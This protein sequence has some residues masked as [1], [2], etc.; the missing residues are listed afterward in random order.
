MIDD[1]S[2]SRKTFAAESPWPRSG[3][4]A[5]ICGRNEVRDPCSAS[6]DWAHARSA[7]AASRRARTSPSA[8]NDAMNCVPLISESPSFA[9]SRNGSSPTRASASSPGSRSPSTNA[10]PSPTSGSARC[11]SGARSPDAPTEP[12]LGT[13]GT[14]PR[15]RHSS[16][17]ST[18]S[19]RAP[20][21]PFGQ[22]VR[23][24]QHRRADDLVVV[25]LADAAR[26]RT[27]Q[28]ELQLL[29][30][31]FRDGTRDEA[32]EPGVDAVRVLARAVGRALDELPRDA[33]LRAGGVGQRSRIAV[34]R[35]GPDVGDREVV[36]GE[37]D[38]GALGHGASL[39]PSLRRPSTCPQGVQR[40]PAVTV[41]GNV[42]RRGAGLVTTSG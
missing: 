27:E 20:E 2:R 14:T 9:S 17:S 6:S 21:V 37:A 32:A 34:D 13:T 1:P 18:V 15:F 5:W 25:R 24:Q 31:L 30:Q 11:A 16:S 35:D 12:R 7:A 41:R 36:A 19:I 29:G 10:S 26:V 42:C 3:R 22:R 23:P 8:A 38:R 33:H 40:P 39:A 28:A 4:S